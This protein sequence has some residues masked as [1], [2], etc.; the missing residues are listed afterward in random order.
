M[1]VKRARNA[2]P[3]SERKPSRAELNWA[4]KNRGE[5]AGNVAFAYRNLEGTNFS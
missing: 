3:R 2:N 5:S 1:N 4:V